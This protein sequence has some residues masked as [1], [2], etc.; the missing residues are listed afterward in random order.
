MEFNGKGF[1]TIKKEQEAK[2]EAMN[3]W[4]HSS[5]QEIEDRIRE[6]KLRKPIKVED[7]VRLYA[8]SKIVKPQKFIIITNRLHSS[9]IEDITVHQ[10]E[11]HSEDEAAI[12]ALR[13]DGWNIPDDNKIAKEW[14]EETDD[15]YTVIESIW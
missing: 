2:D 13:I 7:I 9:H 8:L 4:Y 12:I 11:A 14:L 10:V 1:E 3:W 15:I 5:D 6:H